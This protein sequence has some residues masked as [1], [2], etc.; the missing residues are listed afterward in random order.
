MGLLH[1]EF[2]EYILFYTEHFYS[3][4]EFMSVET[5]FFLFWQTI[6]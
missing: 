3:A 4:R 5:F 6:V 1:G 2:L